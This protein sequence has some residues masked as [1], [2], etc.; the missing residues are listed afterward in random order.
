M[1]VFHRSFLVLFLAAC[2]SAIASAA[3]QPP[4]ENK[5]AEAQPI[6]I[7]RGHVASFPRVIT[8]KITDA[9][10]KPVSGAL[11]EWGPDYP[12]DAPR[13]STRSGDDGTY[14]LEAKKA[15]GRFKLGISASGF[16]PHWQTGLVPGPRSAPTELDVKL[17][18]ETTLRVTIVDEAGLPIPG[19][20]VLPMT[21]Q[22]GFESSFSSVQQPEPIPGHDK[23]TLCDEQGVYL[24]R[25]LLPDPE[26]LMPKADGD[27]Q[28]V[29]EHKDRFN[30]EGW[31]S[32]RITQNGK[33]VHEHQISRKEYFESLGLIRVVV[34]DYRN[35]LAP[36]ITNGTIFGEVVDPNGEPVKEYHVTLRHRT[37]SLAVNDPEG[38]FQW[39]KTFDPES[40]YELR[41]FAKGFAPLT[42]RISPRATSQAKPELLKLTS[43]KSAEFLLLDGQTSKPLPNVVVVTGIS[44]KSGW[45]YVEWSD[46]KNYADGHHALEYVLR[47]T[48]NAEGRITV[49]EGEEPATLLILAA[50]YARMVVTPALRPDPNEAGVIP[51]PLPPAASIRGVAVPD[52]RLSQQAD[53][54]SLHFAST[55]RF[56]HMFHGLK[57]DQNGECLIDS[58]AAGDYFLTLMHSEGNMSTSCWT[59]KI[60]LKAGEHVKVPLG[61]MIGTLTVSGRTSPFTQIRLTPKPNPYVVNL[62]LTKRKPE[63]TSVATI[64]D[65]DGY[66]EFDHVETGAYQVE[67]GG[68]DRHS[69]RI[70]L[71]G[72]KGPSEIVL[73]KDTHIDYETGK[74]TPPEA[75]IDSPAEKKSS[76]E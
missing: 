11:I 12:H 71:G 60:T 27:N 65:V 52:S 76:M 22:T 64:S 44:K 42:R 43:H 5:I 67:L 66:F 70:W 28:A 26:P 36:R 9:S 40:A 21:P 33:W 47:V 59:K 4:T 1:L 39:G 61:E 23:P 17:V 35:P 34:P 30:K 19:L 16:S 38:R 48:S 32:L 37:E 7:K 73:T 25:Q 8:G 13:E 75:A 29:S 58:L 45:N 3:D 62:D 20:E 51:I 74:V 63:I 68:L 56:D 6:E 31:L 49:A 15:G 46:L 24:L 69:Y 50:G 55:D 41:I 72:A 2:Q 54:V 14:R 53:G 10:D 18:V 57:R